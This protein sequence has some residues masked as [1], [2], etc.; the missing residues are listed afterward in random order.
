MYVQKYYK[1][2]FLNLLNHAYDDQL[3]S[4]NTQFISY[5]NSK[6]DISSFYVMTLSILADSIED[7]YYDMTE[8]YESA[9]VEY[10]LENDLD[11]IG[12]IVGCPRPQATKSGV[13]L[14]FTLG[15]TYE[16]SIVL[17]EGIVVST[18]EGI[19]YFTTES[20]TVPSNTEQ[21]KVY[22]LSFEEGVGTRVLA[23]KL[24]LLRSTITLEDNTAIS[25]S[26]TNENPS[27]GGDEAYTDDEYRILLMD[28]IENHTKGSKEAYERYFADFDGLNSYKLIPNWNGISGTVKVVLE[29]GYP[30]QLKEAYD[31]LM[32]TVC[33]F[34]EDIV[35]FAP[36]YVPIDIYA[37]CNVDI[38]EVNPFSDTE[39]EEIKSR[40][41]DA[42]TTFVNG[43]VFNYTGLGIGEDF[44]PYKLGVFLSET[45]PELKNVAFYDKSSGDGSLV[46]ASPV[47]ITDEEKGKTHTIN[48]IME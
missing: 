21:V 27:S 38:D 41:T 7:V 23:D 45:I 3:I 1:D 5:V 34:S 10:A 43:D 48:V 14:T 8:V 11:D 44:I 29:P 46:P 22:A 16:E 19:N 42:I 35:M 40:I 4:H 13:E 37:R 28:W 17:P 18:L 15:T 12:L 39:K 6:K 31:G 30:Y 33:Q 47:T 26:V 32:D 20:V 36:D 24:T 25:L 9:K 2:L